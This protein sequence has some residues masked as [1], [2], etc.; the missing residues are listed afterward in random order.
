MLQ[1]TNAVT[2]IILE[3]IRKESKKIFPESVQM[4]YDF[5]VMFI[6]FKSMDPV[7]DPHAM[8]TKMNSDPGDKMNAYIHYCRYPN[9]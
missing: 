5:I 6:N 1:L 7:S 9:K 8:H 3:S 4:F 2:I